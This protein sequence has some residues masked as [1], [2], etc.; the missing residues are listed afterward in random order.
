VAKEALSLN[1]DEYEW[2]TQTAEVLVCEILK[3]MAGIQ[4][5]RLPDCAQ[6]A[7]LRLDA[8]CAHIRGDCCMEVQL[9]TEPESFYRLTR[10]ISGED[11]L[12]EAEIQEY[13]TEFFNV[14]CGRFISAI[15]DRDHIL[16]RF[17]P[18][19]YQKSACAPDSD[20]SAELHTLAFRTELEELFEFSW[21]KGLGS[22][23]A[24]NGRSEV[25]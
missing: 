7:G 6:L 22:S 5:R 1:E 9:R 14:L 24:E 12:G 18:P 13:A 11:P 20:T 8:V 10:N 2:V 15:C 16:M 17:D 25:L 4:A 21:G 3:Q 23:V 19:E